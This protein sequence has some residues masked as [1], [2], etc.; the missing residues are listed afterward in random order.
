MINLE[1]S[2]IE[3][4]PQDAFDALMKDAEQYECTFEDVDDLQEYIREGGD[5]NEEMGSSYV[6][7][8]YFME[9]NGFLFECYGSQYIKDQLICDEQMDSSVYITNVNEKKE[10]EQ[11]EKADK[12]NKAKSESFKKWDD[13]FD[14]INADLGLDTETTVKLKEIM[15]GYKFPTKFK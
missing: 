4:I 10:V 2:K 3:D 7:N 15:S 13:F 1:V 8:T 11:K 12:A 6:E 5:Y 9:V 14:G